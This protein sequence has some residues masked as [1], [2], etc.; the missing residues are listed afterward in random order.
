MTTTTTDAALGERLVAVIEAIHDGNARLWANSAW[1]Q[2]THRLGDGRLLATRKPINGGRNW[3]VGI[4]L[5][6]IAADRVADDEVR[7][8]NFLTLKDDGT[9]KFESADGRFV[10]G[11]ALLDWVEAQPWGKGDT[12][13]Q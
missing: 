4:N 9:V 2:A 11:V 1:E 5:N 13:V 8:L 3:T 6:G 7:H 12:R 10:D